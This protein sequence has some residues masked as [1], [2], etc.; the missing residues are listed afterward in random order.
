MVGSI[1]IVSAL[2]LSTATPALTEG[3]LAGLRGNGQLFGSGISP[4]ID[5]SQDLRRPQA[6]PAF[7]YTTTADR[8]PY[9]KLV[10]L[11]QFTGQIWAARNDPTDTRNTVD[12]IETPPGLFAR[13]KTTEA[14]TSVVIDGVET[15]WLP[16][17]SPATSIETPGSQVACASVTRNRT[18]PP[19]PVPPPR[20][21][22]RGSTSRP[23][24]GSDAGVD[25]FIT[26]RMGGAPDHPMTVAFPEGEYLK[27]LVLVK[28]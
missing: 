15:T 19:P 25:G 14:K 22:G 9:F 13:V 16:A 2:V 12:N 23:G 21:P 4:M 8:Q 24:A 6:A 27:G 26:E 3:G 20:S 5:L 10:T 28:K 11:D 1:G 7:H 17:P 18:V